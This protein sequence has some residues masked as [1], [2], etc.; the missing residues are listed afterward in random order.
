MRAFFLPED[1]FRASHLLSGLLSGARVGQHRHA[2]PVKLFLPQNIH[3]N[4]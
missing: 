1:G 4:E 3:L 2:R